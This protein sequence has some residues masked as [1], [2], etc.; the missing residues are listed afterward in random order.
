MHFVN[1][2][3]EKFELPV[4]STANVV[5]GKRLSVT[6]AYGQSTTWYWLGI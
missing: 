2:A 1:L 6:L 5:R 4:A 3:L